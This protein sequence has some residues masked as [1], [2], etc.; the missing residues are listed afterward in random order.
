MPLLVIA[1]AA[2]KFVLPQV[3]ALIKASVQA[4]DTIRNGKRPTKSKGAAD[5]DTINTLRTAVEDIE[6]RLET[7][8]AATES[9]AEIIVQLTKHNAVLG[10]WL[11]LVSVG[12][13]LSTGIGL[14]GLLLTL[15]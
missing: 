13:A 10:R 3:P 1:S 9:Q 15:M 4:Y 8:E 2:L 12:M 6:K 5:S 11:L 7:Q 14:T